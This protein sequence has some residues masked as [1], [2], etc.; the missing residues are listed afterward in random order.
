MLNLG[1]EYEAQFQVIG[2]IS[3]LKNGD[4]GIAA[5]FCVSALP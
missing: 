5:V 3:K 1:A 2:R 4:N